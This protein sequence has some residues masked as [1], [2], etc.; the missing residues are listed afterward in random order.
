MCYGW[1]WF[2]YCNYH[3]KPTFQFT[4]DDAFLTDFRRFGGTFFGRKLTHVDIYFQA[5]FLM[6]CWLKFGAKKVPKMNPKAN[7]FKLFWNI[8][9]TKCPLWASGATL[10][11]HGPHRVHK[12]STCA[13]WA[14]FLVG[15]GVDVGS[16][17]VQFWVILGRTCWHLG[18]SK[19][20]LRAT[21]HP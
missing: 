6:S 1:M 13:V 18:C 17:L 20:T 15:L 10:G 9:S 16:I 14:S 5:S 21:G 8:G 19:T 11:S 12:M 7:S 3:M 4:L 2:L